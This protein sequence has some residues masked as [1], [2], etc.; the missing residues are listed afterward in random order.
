[1]LQGGSRI[2][3]QT[4]VGEPKRYSET[5]SISTRGLKDTLQISRGRQIENAINASKVVARDQAPLGLGGLQKI[6]SH[7]VA[8]SRH[9]K[10]ECRSTDL[11]FVRL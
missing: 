11:P 1:M 10:S 2:T 7:G 8:G 6:A 5:R 3:S 4:A 9:S